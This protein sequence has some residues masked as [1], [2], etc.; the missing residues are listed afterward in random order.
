MIPDR[1]ADVFT[2]S[3]ESRAK[4]EQIH[5]L[6]DRHACLVSSKAVVLL[7]LDAAS[8]GSVSDLPK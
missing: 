5:T 3:S 1:F 8:L 7:K 6:A 2:A 4:C